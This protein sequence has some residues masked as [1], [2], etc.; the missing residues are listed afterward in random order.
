MNDDSVQ[1]TDPPAT[2]PRQAVAPPA[3]PHPTHLMHSTADG[4][5]VPTEPPPSNVPLSGPIS[6]VPSTVDER[7]CLTD[8]PPPMSFTASTSPRRAT[9]TLMTGA[10]AGEVFTVTGECE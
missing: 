3:L 7:S 2:L 5:G 8:A 1:R 10:N 4:D 9:L 6:A